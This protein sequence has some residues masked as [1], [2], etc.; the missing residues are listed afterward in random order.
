[1]LIQELESE[2]S[3]KQHCIDELCEV[4][5]GG[6]FIY[7]MKITCLYSYWFPNERS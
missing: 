2:Q 5:E 3:H 4:L 1:M 6:K 7:H